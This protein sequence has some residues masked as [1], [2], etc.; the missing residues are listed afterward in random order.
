MS[1]TAPNIDKGAHKR[2]F[3]P[4]DLYGHGGRFLPNPKDWIVDETTKKINVVVNVDYALYTYS[5]EPWVPSDE[6]S[7]D[8]IKGTNSFLS[9]MMYKFYVDESKS[10]P[11]LTMDSR[12]AFAPGSDSIKVF[13][14]TDITDD[15]DC[16]SGY[17]R[18]GELVSKS[19]PMFTADNLRFPLEGVVTRPTLDDKALL[20]FVVHND[21]GRVSVTERAQLIKTA[22]TSKAE[23]A[24]RVV[25]SVSLHSPW[26]ESPSS[27]L[28][29]LP[30]NI[31]LDDIAL[32]VKV[33]YS[34]RTVT[35][36][37]DGDRAKLVGL[38]SSGAYDPVYLSTNVGKEI[39]LVFSY[40]LASDESYVGPDLSGDTIVKDYRAIPEAVDGAYSLKLFVVP[41]WV[42]A[43]TG[44]RL[45]YFLYDLRRGIPYE[46][47]AHVRAATNGGVFDPYLYNT[48]QKLIVQVNTKDVNSSY[49]DHTFPQSFYIT[50]LNEGDNPGSN[51]MLGYLPNTDE[52][53][54]QVFGTYDYDN[55]TYSTVKVDC[56]CSSL[57]EWLE[58]VYDR[59]Y[60]LYD[61]K[62][63]SKPLTPTH[64]I[65]TVNSHSVT[66]PIADWHQG[67][68]FEQNI[69][70]GTVATIRWINKQP[71][72]DLELG[73]SSM[74]LYP[75]TVL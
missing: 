27:N 11:T 52:Y 53:G 13:L 32:Q 31:S 23:S 65:V 70:P 22:N 16:I 7:E 9:P 14:G 68:T 42:G 49:K 6:D 41:E 61:R 57:T 28:L 74:L 8:I 26:L 35:I 64:F 4:E 39:P 60:P 73:M 33:E 30:T 3:N 5:T 21:A 59:I 75:E 56:G 62:M 19:I 15:G 71:K 54:H 55:V 58:R 2:L 36:P 47:T 25:K 24:A 20:T 10:P 44:W 50:L 17:I 46:A 37:L 43:A 63:E 66:L 34:D 45:R 51:F 29:R 18:G 40:R 69:Q 48:K 67:I 38:K 12:I 72:D 1:V